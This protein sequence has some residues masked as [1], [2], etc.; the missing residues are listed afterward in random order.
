MKLAYIKHYFSKSLKISSISYKENNH[1]VLS[2]ALRLEPNK[3]MLSQLMKE[4]LN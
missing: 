3:E 4:K 2:T 1:N